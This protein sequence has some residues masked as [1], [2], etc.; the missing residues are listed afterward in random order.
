MRGPDLVRFAAFGGGG[1]AQHTKCAA[2][3]QSTVGGG[4]DPDGLWQQHTA[5]QPGSY[6]HAGNACSG[7]QQ[8]GG[9]AARSGCGAD[10]D[11]G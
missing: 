9:D 3:C 2:D 7:K 8:H 11:R 5:A 10:Y 1:D 6:D 4:L